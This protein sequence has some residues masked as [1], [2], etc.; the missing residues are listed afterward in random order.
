MVLFFSFLFFDRFFLFCLAH[1]SEEPPKPASGP[2]SGRGGK[3]ERKTWGGKRKG[4]GAKKKPD[5]ADNNVETLK[6]EDEIDSLRLLIKE[7]K[8]P[9]ELERHLDKM[10]KILAAWEE[11]QEQLKDECERLFAKNQQDEALLEQ[12]RAE[13]AVL[14]LFSGSGISKEKN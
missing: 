2:G 8:D 7:T 14:G 1:S 10:Q 11:Q 9:L 13:K 6:S 3:R 12:V 5:N 4:A